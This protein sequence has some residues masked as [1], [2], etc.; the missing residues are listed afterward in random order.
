MAQSTEVTKPI[1]RYTRADFAALRARLNGIAIAR[2]SQLY[3]TDDDLAALGCETPTQLEARLHAM[4]DHLI[5]RAIVANRLLADGLRHAHHSDKWSAVA[6]RYLFQAAEFSTHQPVP[7]D[8]LSAWL[9]PRVSANLRAEGVRTIGELMVW[10][11][12]RGS[13]WFRP[14]R[15]LGK[16]KAEALL[17]WLRQHEATIGALAPLTATHVTVDAQRITLRADHAILVPIEHIRLPAELDG[18]VGL[19]RAHAQALV[20][21]RD[22]LEAIEAFLMRYAGRDKTIRAYKRELERL[23][24]WAIYRRRKPLSSLLV[25]DGQAYL[26]FL[27]DPDPAWCGKKTAR[28]SVRWRPFE[29]PLSAPSQNHALVIIR[30]FFAWLVDVRYLAANPW[31]AVGKVMQ[32]QKIDPIQIDKALPEGFWNAL[33]SPGG[34]LDQAIENGD[35]TKWG[36][37][38]LARAAILLIGHTGLR[39]EEAATATRRRLRKLPD[40]PALWELQVLG[41]RKK[42]RAVFLPERVVEALRSHWDDRGEEFEVISDAHLLSPLVIPPEIHA[43]RKHAG[44]EA[45]AGFAPDSL[46]KVITKSLR[47][48]AENPLLAMTDL[49]REFLA[50]RGV[51]AFRHTFGT[52]A[53]AKG[54]PLDVL[55]RTL[56][57]ASLQTTTIYVQ[58][59]RKRSIE[60]MSRFFETGSLSR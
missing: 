38:R 3:Y 51:H 54:V 40:H 10:I 55:Q 41:K 34:Y 32:E 19:N 13:G 47:E 15:R 23:L 59:E 42:W 30:A 20:S 8:T 12:A 37:W 5:E 52:L 36:Q 2:I 35:P 39:R 58:A 49:E 1:P 21:A 6:M 11:G 56:G 25:E 43:L 48:I 60:E 18:S 44:A 33:A 4:R 7:E 22:D 27:A 17:R 46:Y 45:A 9:K 16:G 28:A 26:T 31:S 14:I 29:G 53:A 57:H 50:S 24:L